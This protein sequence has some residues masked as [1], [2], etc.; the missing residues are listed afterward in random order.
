MRMGGLLACMLICTC[1]ASAGPPRSLEQAIGAS[2]WHLIS[3]EATAYMC[4]FGGDP[5]AEYLAIAAKN[6]L[7]NPYPIAARARTYGADWFVA[8]L[9]RVI[10]DIALDQ[11]DQFWCDVCFAPVSDTPVPAVHWLA[12]LCQRYPRSPAAW[13]C[14]AA[15]A[16][17]APK[18][19]PLPILPAAEKAASLAPR[20]AVCWLFL[21][22]ASAE[23]GHRE[24]AEAALNQAVRCAPQS[25]LIHALA[26]AVLEPLSP[27]AAESMARRAIALSRPGQ[28][29]RLA[30]YGLLASRLDKLS[31]FQRRA[32]LA[33][34]KSE[35]QACP[36]P[37]IAA[38][39]LLGLSQ[40]DSRVEALLP[41][42][43]QK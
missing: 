12:S 41:K 43:G 24:R 21:G 31:Q 8:I 40:L 3:R 11:D 42:P 30:A 20:S 6:R 28:L 1:L 35:L 38:V 36:L 37:L 14:Y 22:C 33:R 7:A 13:A 18:P 27:T 34:I 32:L 39:P 2:D 23:E 17:Q 16:L 10:A 29:S 15:L 9:L 26:A 19:P 4:R 25:P 5:T